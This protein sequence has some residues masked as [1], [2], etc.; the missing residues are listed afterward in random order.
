MFIT[1]ALDGPSFSIDLEMI[2]E[3]KIDD[4]KSLKDRLICEGIVEVYVCCAHNLLTSTVQKN[5]QLVSL[6]VDV[7]QALQAT[8][9]RSLVLELRSLTAEYLPAFVQAL[10]NTQIH[11]LILKD[12][13]IAKHALAVAQA[14]HNTHVHTLDLSYNNIGNYAPAV[15]QALHNTRVHT[16]NLSYNNIAEHA[17]ALAQALCNTRIHTLDL[18]GNGIRQHGPAMAQALQ[19]APVRILSLKDN[20]LAWYAPAT[21][22]ALQNTQVHVLDL[23]DNRI[24]NGAP[25]FAQALQTSN[26]TVLDLSDNNIDNHTMLEFFQAL[27]GAKVKTLHLSGSLF[28]REQP[29][30]QMAEALANT[31]VCS[32]EGC[33]YPKEIKQ[34]ILDNRRRIYV[35]CLNTAEYQGAFLKKL[36]QQSFPWNRVTFPLSIARLI[37]Q[38]LGYE[39]DENLQKRFLNKLRLCVPEDL[40]LLDE[41]VSNSAESTKQP[42]EEYLVANKKQKIS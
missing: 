19:N 37:M 41:E 12:R 9:V 40:S 5:A 23:T 21:M 26:I 38:F 39:E 11:T 8:L 20:D 24:A 36:Y 42:E 1:Y 6:G 18:N 7:V 2:E 31:S 14:L 10:H 3:D 13:A 4:F 25:L 35:Q 32:I 22:R 34:A 15:A 28:S 30:Q 27:Q 33:I 29:Y 16:L 17:P